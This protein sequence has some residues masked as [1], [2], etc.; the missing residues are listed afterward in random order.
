MRKKIPL[1]QVKFDIVLLAGFAVWVYILHCVY[2]ATPFL[3]WLDEKYPIVSLLLFGVALLSPLYL[4]ERI[5]RMERERIE[6]ATKK[7]DGRP[8]L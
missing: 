4:G 8:S 2:E 5:E 1:G 3:Q 7:S 6:R